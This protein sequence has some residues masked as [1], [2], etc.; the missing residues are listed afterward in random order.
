MNR[1]VSRRRAVFLNVEALDQRIALSSAMSPAMAA[2]AVVGNAV[3]RSATPIRVTVKGQYTIPLSEPGGSLTY[4]LA[5]TG[6]ASPLGQ[7]AAIG[8]IRTPASTGGGYGQNQGLLTLSN[9]Q[10]ALTLR[11]TGPVQARVTSLV[12]QFAVQSGTGAYQ[13][14][15]GR[16]IVTL[17]LTPTSIDSGGEFTLILHSRRRP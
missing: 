1:S 11:L 15:F 5:G 6:K 3:N 14:L 9:A 4:T 2:T 10:G 8:T 12:R 13:G 16:G 7:V 17:H